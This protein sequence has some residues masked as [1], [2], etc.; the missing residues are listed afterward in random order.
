M[1][2]VETYQSYAKA[3]YMSE[4]GAGKTQRPSDAMS[5]AEVIAPW[6]TRSGSSLEVFDSRLQMKGIDTAAFVGMLQSGDIPSVTEMQ[7]EQTLEDVLNH[8]PTHQWM[9]NNLQLGVA[10]FTAPFLHEMERKLRISGFLERLKPIIGD[11]VL[12]NVL[13]CLMNDLRL[14]SD[15]AVVYDFHLCRE[16]K[17]DLTLEAYLEEWADD[18]EAWK[19]ILLKF[20]VL[21][22]MMSEHLARSLRNGLELFGRLEEDYAQLQE[23]FLGGMPAVLQRVE[24]SA[25]DSHQ[26]GRT[27]T[28]LHFDNGTTIV[29]KPRSLQTDMAFTQWLNW[30]ERNGL[31]DGPIAARTIDRGHYGWQQYV[32][33]QPCAN[34][35]QVTRYYYRMGV[36]SGIFHLFQ[37]TDMHYENIVASGEMP[38]VIDMETIVSNTVFKTGVVPFP[39][40]ELQRT[41]LTSGLYPT[42]I[43]F[44]TRFDFDI[45]GIAG[46]PDQKST[47]MTGWKLQNEEGSTPRYEQVSFVTSHQQHL[48]RLNGEIINPVQY[49]SDITRGFEAVYRIF[50]DKQEQL[51]DVVSTLFACAR[52]RALL[53]PTFLY[54]RFLTASIHPDNLGDGLKREY[55]LEMLWNITKTEPT[56]EHIVWSEIQ[57][58]LNNDIPYFTFGIDGTSIT[59]SR[60]TEI[61]DVFQQSSLDIIRRQ[62]DRLGEEDLAL[63]LRLISSSLHYNAVREMDAAA[64]EALPGYKNATEEPLLD[65]M[66]EARRIADYLIEQSI[67]DDEFVSWIGVRNQDEKCVWQALDYSMYSGIMGITVFMGQMY[68]QTKEPK[69]RDIAVKSFRYVMS[70]FERIKGEMSPSVFNGLGTVVYA[71][72]YLNELFEF[73]EA[74][75]F[76]ME[77]LDSI[78]IA[79]QSGNEIMQGNGYKETEPIVDFLDGYAG[80]VTLCTNIWEVTREQAAYDTAVLYGQYLLDRLKSV[81]VTWTGFAH[82]SS[83]IIYA[84]DKLELCG[85][86]E[87]R[88]LRAK[89]IEFEALNFDETHRNWCDL[90]EHVT[91][92]YSTY[93][94]CHGAPG[95]L[96]GRT[97]AQDADLTPD[98][99]QAVLDAVMNATNSLPRL[100]LCHGLFGNINIL[101]DISTAEWG[102]EYK[103]V[104]EQYI[105][106]SLKRTDI[107]TILE[108]MQLRSLLGLMLGITGVGWTLL[109]LHNRSIP[110]LLTLGFPSGKGVT[111]FDA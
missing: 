103:S 87:G 3:A 73:P 53:R 14:L 59:D 77:L 10:L 75:R 39:S 102:R 85:W 95:V 44:N 98:Q 79:P 29:Y 107:R 86:Q 99:L 33:H 12:Q 94:W 4:R 61:Q 31:E 32:E 100:S 34:E 57:D 2:T 27:V 104:I 97:L 47:N 88:E 91:S 80:I 35:E 62:I 70:V 105:A 66:L 68:D 55:L 30:L 43:L 48:V 58:L 23:T 50:L 9:R 78:R 26:D 65:P 41:V 19:R 1:T 92:P 93:Y 6:L 36:L 82:G 76:A 64:V 22:R 109:R 38:Y 69:Y 71:G 46:K 40:S 101:L 45:S 42:G 37:S 90:R 67:V 81:P 5:E 11:A 54:G 51:L 60:G 111:G 20:P 18:A 8:W 84:L 110:S 7:W 25:G 21:A 63:Q 15:K 56:F 83:G 16:S 96:L 49:I 72:I 108:G 28:L 17:P 24:M 89:L 13:Q 52:C 106:Q 74:R